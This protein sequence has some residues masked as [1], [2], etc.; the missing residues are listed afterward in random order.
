[1]SVCW[2]ARGWTG[3]S[4]ARVWG[5]LPLIAMSAEWPLP[6]SHA[7]PS[8]R[9]PGFARTSGLCRLREHIGGKFAILAST[10]IVN[11]RM[12][13]LAGVEPAHSRFVTGR[14]IRCA[15]G[16]GWSLEDS[17]FRPSASRADA[18]ASWAKRPGGA[19]RSIRPAPRHG[20][21]RLTGLEPATSRVTAWR[22]DQ[23]S[24]S[25][26]RDVRSP[27]RTRTFTCRLNGTLLFQLSY[28]G[29]AAN[30]SAAVLQCWLQRVAEAGLEPA[31][32]LVM[33]QVPS[34]LGHSAVAP[35]RLELRSRV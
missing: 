10:E 17:N 30:V 26:I 5:R 14:A 33:S 16:A 25:L 21:A 31:N 35:R 27:E 3:Q 11:L 7:Q 20:Q 29:T 4:L 28:R 13:P 9:T 8:S 32:L 22:S 18:L 6:G 23:L 1:M 15:T 24:Y 12:A 34:Q 19:G 2:V